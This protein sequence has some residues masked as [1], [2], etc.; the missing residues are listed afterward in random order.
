MDLTNRLNRRNRWAFPPEPVPPNPEDKFWR[1][2]DIHTA[3]SHLP[4]MSP[5]APCR[6]PLPKNPDGP[7]HTAPSHLPAMFPGGWTGLPGQNLNG[8]NMDDD[9]GA[10]RDNSDT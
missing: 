5:K 2:S 4:V 3:P 8:D 6:G 10:D 1:F 7:P 9:K